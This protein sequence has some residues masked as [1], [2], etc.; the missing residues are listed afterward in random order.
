MSDHENYPT[1]R[2]GAAQLGRTADRFQS[3]LERY[4]S[5]V[6]RDD[7]PAA[8]GSD[9]VDRG[10]LYWNIEN[11]LVR[12]VMTR[13]VVSVGED[14]PFKEIVDALAVHRISA[15]PVVDA[16][17]KVVGIVSESD[18]LAKVVSGGGRTRPIREGHA[19]RRGARRKAQA[20]IA[21][22]LMSAPVVTVHE[23][24]SVVHAARKAALEHVRRLPVV[25]ADGVLVGIATRSD[26]LRVF[27]RGDA[28]IRSHL[29]DAVLAH[30]FLLDVSA[31]EVTVLAG[32]VTLT[33][34][35]ERRIVIAPLLDAVR[36]TAGVVGVHDELTYRVDDTFQPPPRYPLY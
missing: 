15:V 9:A 11:N 32:V 18:L 35:V 36:A 27:L 19:T 7:E 20:E 22:E 23:D 33:G 2:D 4:L 34:Q 24:V 16:S 6:A 17:R 30:Q 25:D 10:E 31:I 8:G 12:D 21:G 14:A 3:A 5:A 29:V 1:S 28:E 26:L 13:S